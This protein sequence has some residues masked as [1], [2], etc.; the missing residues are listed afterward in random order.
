[1]E[2]KVDNKLLNKVFF[3][4]FMYGS[5]WNY[6]RMQN[7]GFLYVILPI[8]KSVYKDDK[9]GLSEAMTRHMEFFNTH[10]ST[11]P[12][13]MGVTAALE[14][15]EKNE[16]AKSIRGLKTGLMGPLAGI[17][18]SMIGLTI[19]PIIFSIGASYGIEGNAFGIFLALFLFNI[20]NVSLKY[21]GLKYGYSKGS[22]LLSRED[23]KS[24]LE[25]ITN[26]AIALGLIIM[27]GL[28]PAWVGI[29]VGLQYT[30]GELVVSV[31]ETLNKVFPGLLPLL[32]TLGAY[33]LVKKGKN[34]VWIILGM[35][36]IS[37]VLVYFG[38]LK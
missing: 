17:G 15:K 9:K 27:G 19:T 7:L 11:A 2:K 34:P 3:R 32:L 18:D 22:E 1:M 4:N 21:F 38:I 36:F 24:N 31:Q 25:Q 35:M 13:I 28:I 10:Q 37:I 20:F 33:K 8:L 16:G 5:S 6:E 26:I 12:F 30:Q 14:E 23:T 29:N